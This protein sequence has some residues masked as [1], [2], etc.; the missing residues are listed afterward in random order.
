MIT[1]RR[2]I[3]AGAALATGIGARTDA[4]ADDPFASL[5]AG[6]YLPLYNFL[7]TQTDN[8]QRQFF[9]H[10]AAMVGDEAHA[11]LPPEEA[12]R[13]EP[14]LT[15]AMATD[16]IEAI[17]AA[18]R[19]R[20]VVII[21]EAHSVSLNRAFNEHLLIALSG[22]GFGWLA[23]E[24]F[25]SSDSPGTP[26]TTWRKGMAV[27]PDLGF[28]TKDP[29]FAQ[30]IR[31]ALK[32]GYKLAN[33]ETRGDQNPTDVS[34]DMAK[35]IAEREQAEADN[36]IEMVFSK[37]P[38][39]RVLVWCG[40]GHL[41]KY[42][43]PDGRLAFAA[44]FMA[45]TG[46]EPLTVD[47]SASWPA[48][49]RKDDVPRVRRVIEH[50]SPTKPIVVRQGDSRVLWGIRQD[51]ADLTVFHPRLDRIGGRPGWL[52]QAAERKRVQFILPRGA[53]KQT[54]LIQCLH[55]EEGKDSIP[56]D[57]YLIGA[58]LGHATFFLRAGR[59][60]V[61]LETEGGHVSL[62]SLTA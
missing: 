59:Y 56:A 47:Q 19:G 52:A 17:V 20:Q 32:L 39:A 28:Y 6:R 38:N 37:D 7:S 8:G 16:A 23:A 46:I 22:E 26:V 12:D 5:N 49:S 13:S 42:Q 44:R 48:L 21:N 33:Y 50:F 4:A 57:Q 14:D 24:T 15:G 62:G 45:K 25:R 11:L 43:S 35:S 31:S 58:D 36:L 18:S 41:Q 27:P 9:A 30:A 53:V 10:I 1:R 54:A 55:T 34:K 51:Y 3:L 29:V 40:H 60:D 2:L 61:R